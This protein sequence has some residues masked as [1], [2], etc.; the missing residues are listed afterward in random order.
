MSH[1]D[2]NRPGVPENGP[3]PQEPID[4]DVDLHIPQHVRELRRTPGAVLAAIAVGG[5]CGAVARHGMDVWF[6]RDPGDFAWATFLV[7][8]SGCLLIGVLMVVVTQV[9]PHSR[10][11]RPFLGVGL[12]GGYTTF[13][14][15]IVDAQLMLTAAEPD[16]AGALLF[17]AANV[18]GGLA[19]AWIGVALTERVLRRPIAAVAARQRGGQT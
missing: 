13:S 14:T 16:A 10:L 4:S 18:V 8:L 12:L 1:R 17:L 7:N 19:A 3:R 2:P 11:L 9:V 15:H 5:A 6:S